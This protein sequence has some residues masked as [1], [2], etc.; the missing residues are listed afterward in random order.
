M[1]DEARGRYAEETKEPPMQYFTRATQLLRRNGPGDTSRPR[2]YYYRYWRETPTLR[3]RA[4]PATRLG[5]ATRVA[6]R[7]DKEGE[8][9]L[10]KAAAYMATP[11]P[12]TL[13]LDR[14]RGLRVKRL[15]DI[16]VFLLLICAGFAVWTL[17][18]L[19]E[20]VAFKEKWE[21][22]V[23]GSDPRIVPDVAWRDDVF[24]VEKRSALVE[25]GEHLLRVVGDANPLSE[26]GFGGTRGVVLHFTRAAFDDAYAFQHPAYAWLYEGVLRELLDERCDAF[27]FNILVVPPGRDANRTVGVGSHVDQTL[28][29]P[30]TQ[31]EQTAY[32]VSVAYLQVPL[33]EWRRARRGGA[34]P[35]A[36]GRIGVGIPGRPVAPREGLLFEQCGRATARWIKHRD[37]AHLVRGWSSIAW[38][39][40]N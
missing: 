10:A 28:M 27:V 12:S 25:K 17:R 21:D 40:R 9:W 31:R 22:E 35:R 36:A 32:S 4:A 20:V 33:L 16:V 14:K 2:R 23:P 13:M 37:E 11:R 15:L 24:S 6:G 29:Q 5:T 19:V 26:E 18:D 8:E 38:C 30:S 1:A 34:E 7:N 39:P 3:S